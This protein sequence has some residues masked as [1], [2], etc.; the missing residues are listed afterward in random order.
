[1]E[2]VI[3]PTEAFD[4]SN[5]ILTHPVGIQGGACFTKIEHNNKP[6]YIHTTKCQTRQGIVKT[7]KKYYSDLMFDKNSETLINW[8]ENL[9]E[10]CKKLVYE[11]SEWFEK[12]LEEND[13]DLAFNSILRVYKS[14]KYYLVRTNIKSNKDETPI[15]KIYN[16]QATQLSLD[17]I[18]SET[19]IMCVLELQ[20]IK[21]TSRNFQFEIVLHQVMVLN[22]ENL[23]DNCLINI[24]KNNL[25][26][27]KT[28][29]KTKEVEILPN[30][31]TSQVNNINLVNEKLLVEQNNDKS[32]ND[33][34]EFEPLELL[35]K[36]K[37]E[38]K[39]EDITIEFED[40]NEDINKNNEELRE[41]NNNDLYLDKSFNTIS[42][43][44]ETKK[45]IIINV[46][47][48]II[49]SQYL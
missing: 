41:I 32:N 18:N 48:F 38:T 24:N 6:L 10:K 13:I 33:L 30:V 36:D 14:G 42:E 46:I 12:S 49:C 40:L 23:F 7:G 15:I 17:Y 11:K 5:I 4:F 43:K 1:M 37:K 29:G 8:F 9:E 28:L 47:G 20:G 16:E 39:D 2:G 35:E 3:N 27:T 31:N 22:N 19:N 26:T 44:K 25:I 45:L 21:F 34:E